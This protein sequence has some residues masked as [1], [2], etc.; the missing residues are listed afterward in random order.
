MPNRSVQIFWGVDYEQ[1]MGTRSLIA[2]VKSPETDFKDGT[3][4]R[5]TVS[6]VISALM[7]GHSHL[8]TTDDA[9]FDIVYPA[10]DGWPQLAETWRLKLQDKGS[11]MLDSVVLGT[12]QALLC[13]ERRTPGY[14]PEFPAYINRA[15]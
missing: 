3:W 4:K 10:E 13:V 7:E 11:A 15:A 6:G 9:Q 2:C 12:G 8:S 14:G 1:H 5:Q